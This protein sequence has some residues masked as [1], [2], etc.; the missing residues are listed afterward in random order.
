[1]HVLFAACSCMI[2]RETMEQICHPLLFRNG[3]RTYS[4]NLGLWYSTL[5]G[6]IKCWSGELIT[7]KTKWGTWKEAHHGKGSFSRIGNYNYSRKR[8]KSQQCSRSTVYSSKSLLQ[9]SS[10]IHHRVKTANWNTKSACCQS[11]KL[12]QRIKELNS[13][14]GTRCWT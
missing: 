12:K 4:A 7:W 10:L 1:M 6:C 5:T 14:F 13:K 9:L 3:L 2:S 8:S 11:N